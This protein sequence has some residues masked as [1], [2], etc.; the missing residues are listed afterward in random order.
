M[1]RVSKAKPFKEKYESKLEFP[2]GWDGE[3]SV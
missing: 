1:G 2:Y 3:I